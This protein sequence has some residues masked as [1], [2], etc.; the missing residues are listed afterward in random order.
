[1]TTRTL[2]VFSLLIVALFYLGCADTESDTELGDPMDQDTLAMDTSAMDMSGMNSAA[3]TLHATLSG[4]AEVPESGDP[5]GSGTAEVVLDS[6][7]GTVCFTIEVENIAEAGAAHIH[8]GAAG[9]AGPPV[10]DFDVPNNG[11]SGCVDADS[12]VIDDILSS[13][14]EYYVN[15]HNAEFGAGAVRGQLEEST[16]M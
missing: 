1:M 7:E 6:A 11:L 2:S 10:V 14:S 13:P 4:D 5:D 3:D 12:G 15:V 9:T 16:T 8:T